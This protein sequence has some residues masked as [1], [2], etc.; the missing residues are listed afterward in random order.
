MNADDD[1]CGSGYCKDNSKDHR[2]FFKEI[3]GEPDGQN[4]FTEIRNNFSDKLPG[5]VPQNNHGLNVAHGPVVVKTSFYREDGLTGD[6]R[7][8]TQ[9]TFNIHAYQ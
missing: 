1:Q 7:E 6:R 3:T 8:F 5:F 2:E 9:D 4:S